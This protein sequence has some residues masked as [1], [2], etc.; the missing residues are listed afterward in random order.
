MSL[1]TSTQIHKKHNNF[2]YIFFLPRRKAFIYK[3][4]CDVNINMECKSILCWAFVSFDVKWHVMMMLLFNICS[5]IITFLFILYICSTILAG[6][7]FFSLVS[8]WVGIKMQFGLHSFEWSV[9]G[10]LN[11]III[12]VAI[13]ILA[14]IMNASAGFLILLCSVCAQCCF[15][16]T[17]FVCV[18]ALSESV[19]RVPKSCWH[20]LVQVAECTHTHRRNIC[21]VRISYY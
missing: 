11:R 14:I 4:R 15:S 1:T 5:F 21:I 8:T 18:G 3:F 6:W 17:K 16:C 7:C 13:S 19:F 12:Y 10:G 20:P 2:E 9:C